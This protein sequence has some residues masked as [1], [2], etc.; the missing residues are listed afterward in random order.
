MK[1]RINTRITIEAKKSQVFKYLADP[2]F[3]YLWNPQ[4][5]SI[6]TY[7]YLQEGSKYKAKS[8]VMGI[9]IQ[10]FNV[11]TEFTDNQEIEFVNKSGIL[12]YC[13]NFQLK[14][15]SS[16]VLVKCV[17]TIETTS[18]VFAFTTPVLKKLAHRELQSDLKMLKL[19]AESSLS[20][21][22]KNRRIKE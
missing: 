1:A 13:V 6:S 15:S 14:Q 22:S 10:S 8:L 2:K 7:D 4:L 20:Y 9:E 3:H 5:K 19:A 12:H 16:K 17:S 11:I 21:D 18:K